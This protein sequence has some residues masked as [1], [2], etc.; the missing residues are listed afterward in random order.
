[1]WQNVSKKC[2]RCQAVER[3]FVEVFHHLL[4]P[5]TP[6]RLPLMLR[7]EAKPRSAQYQQTCCIYIYIYIQ[8]HIYIYIVFLEICLQSK[9][10]VISFFKAHYGRGD[11]LAL[12]CF[13]VFEKPTAFTYILFSLVLQPI[14]LLQVVFKVLHSNYHIYIYVYANLAIHISLTE[15]THTYSFI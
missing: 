2:V 4:P 13:V 11:T 12:Q 5:A 3:C 10:K 8:L 9:V 7:V 6:I 15:S 1:M 14:P